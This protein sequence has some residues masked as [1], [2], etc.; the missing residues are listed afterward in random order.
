VARIVQSDGKVA[1]KTGVPRVVW[2]RPRVS[3][4]YRGPARIST[5]TVEIPFLG[6]GRSLGDLWIYNA[7]VG[8]FVVSPGPHI[9]V[10]LAEAGC[11][12]CLI[13]GKHGLWNVLSPSAAVAAVQD[14]EP[15]NNEKQVRRST[16]R[17][18]PRKY[19]SIHLKAW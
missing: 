15:H 3:L 11:N 12:R 1:R 16:T 9:W 2:N 10:I 7:K 18:I 4:G 17:H 13:F 5:D 8:E 19:G 14:A 6:I